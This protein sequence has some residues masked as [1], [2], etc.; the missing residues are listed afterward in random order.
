MNIQTIFILQIIADFVFCIVIVFLLAR[1]R[2]S[3]DR[4]ENHV[5]DQELFVK[6]QDL[7]IRSKSD[8]DRFLENLDESCRRFNNLA[9]GLESREKRLAE[10]FADIDRKSERVSLPESKQAF[11]EGDRNYASIAEMLR[12]GFSIEDVA[13]RT[14][15]P[16]GEIALV[17]D[18]EKLRDK[19]S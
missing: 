13:L 16:A 14:G 8:S 2:K 5:I 10:L 15:A 12:D 17:A 4:S 6:L 1:L 18:L 19:E 11:V 3:L 9:V 7:I